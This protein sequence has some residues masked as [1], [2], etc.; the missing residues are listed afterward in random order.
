MRTP[1]GRGAA[2]VIVDEWV[3]GGGWEDSCNISSAAAAHLHP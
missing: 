3:V 2:G 1:T